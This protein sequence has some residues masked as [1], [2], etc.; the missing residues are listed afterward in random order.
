MG[1]V[2]PPADAADEEAYDEAFSAS[3]DVEDIVLEDNHGT[4]AND[5]DDPI[6][7]LLAEAAA[8]AVGDI[9]EESE[10]IPNNNNIVIDYED[11][12]DDSNTFH[13]HNNNDLLELNSTNNSNSTIINNNNNTMMDKEKVGRWSEQEHRVFLEGL[14]TYGKQW[15]TIAG[16]IGTR[17]VVQVRTHAQKYFQKMERSHKP[18]SSSTSATATTLKYNSNPSTVAAATRTSLNAGAK[19][20]KSTT[21]KPVPSPPPRTSEGSN[22]QGGRVEKRKSSSLAGSRSHC[23]PRKRAHTRKHQLVDDAT[24]TRVSVTMGETTAAVG[25]VPEEEED[26]TITATSTMSTGIGNP[27]ATFPVTSTTDV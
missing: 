24:T 22:K 20:P 9:M 19:D 16:W 25:L 27:L 17:T 26:S 1:V 13:H 7:L 8:A 21:G 5:D 11:D 12:D 18:N 15:K 10:S 23:S 6:G 14:A 3:L 4:L 2:T